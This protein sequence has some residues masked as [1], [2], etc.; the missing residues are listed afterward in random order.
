[1]KQINKIIIATGV[2]ALGTMAASASHAAPIVNW[3]YT[4]SSVFLT[5]AG[6]T[7]FNGAGPGN[8]NGCELVSSSSITWG[9]C[10]AAGP[11][12]GRSGI[13][14][15]ASPQTGTIATNG[16]AKA[17]NTYTH[18]NNVLDVDYATLTRA[19]IRATLGLR[20]TGS[21]AAFTEYVATY[22]I[23]FAETANS[24]PCVVASPTPCNDIWVL[25]GSLNNSF[26]VG[27]DQYFFS[28]FAAPS[29]TTLSPAA[30]AATGSA[31]P[32]IGFTTVEGQANQVNFLMAITSDRIEIPE[33]SSLALL[34]LGLVGLAGLARRRKVS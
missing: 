24:A 2:L 29:L 18:S 5:T 23:R 19:T 9:D 33:P 3:D 31:S 20:P 10:P 28:F 25:N 27:A 32:C 21:A 4:V 14:I 6:A 13:G 8:A 30:C 15:T 22:T 34:G 17:A 1:M 12:P 16:A 7:T 26:T 11:G